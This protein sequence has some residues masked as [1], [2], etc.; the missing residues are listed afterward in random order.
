VFLLRI[1]RVLDP[2]TGLTVEISAKIIISDFHSGFS[3]LWVW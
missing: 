3:V 1:A 2:S